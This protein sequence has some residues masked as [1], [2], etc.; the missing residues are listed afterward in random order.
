MSKTFKKI[1][2]LMVALV[3]TTAFAACGDDDG[4]GSGSGNETIVT[5]MKVSPETLLFGKDGGTST[6]SV[7]SATAVSVQSSESWCTVSAGQM[8]ASLKV[9]P[10]TVTVSALTDYSDRTAL[11]TITAGTESRTV[12]VTQT[13]ADRI[14]V[15]PSTQEV[16]VD[17]GTVVVK[18]TANGAYTVSIDKEWVTENTVRGT[19]EDHTHTFTVAANNGGSRTA[20]IT[21]ALN[22]E[23]ATV[24]IT[25]AARQS[26]ISGTASSIARQMYPGWNLGNTLEGCNWRSSSAPIDENYGLSTELD[27]QKTTTTQ[28]VIDFVKSQGF[29]SVRI[30]CNWMCGHISDAAT[31]TIDAAWMA[32][33]KEVVDYCI[34][35][36]L[37]VLLNDHYDGGWVERSFDDLSE[38]TVQKNIGIMNRVWTQIAETFRDY[39][40]H[41]LFGGLNEPDCNNQAKTDV[42]IRYEQAFIDAVRATGG[43]NAKRILVVQGPSTDIDN[44][45]NYFDIS[46][47]T[48]TAQDALMAEVHFYGPWNFCGMEQDESWGKMFWY[49]GSANH[50][51]GST[52]N[53]TWGEEDWLK[54]QFQK[55]KTQFVDKGIPVVIGEYGCQWRDLSSQS[56]EDQSKH[57]ASVK[58]FHKTVN[59]VAI[60]SGMIPFVWDI[61]YASQGGTKGV[62][63]VLNRSSRTVFCQPA[64]DGITEGVAAAQWPN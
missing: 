28:Q 58:L 38:A 2:M 44:T 54:S 16:S 30:P 37:Y 50:Q 59:Q 32:R 46:K 8:S 36:G 14:V 55:M 18:V 63:T 6:V 5:G 29:K 13:A 49:W 57:D 33:V 9:T 56:G 22:N 19:L 25:Q 1:L 23:Q 12:S 64:M 26:T 7:Q 48:D 42:L 61:N 52:R 20:T 51:S 27:W 34:S 62:M 35:D 45:S 4:G 31:H 24:T 21:F 17:G 11:V 47:L 43:N 53:A 41:L 10:V 15:E 60:S 39:D 40:E 3:A